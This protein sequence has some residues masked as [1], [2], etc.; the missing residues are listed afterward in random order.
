MNSTRNRKVVPALSIEAQLKRKVR[1]HLNQLGFVRDPDGLLSPPKTEKSTIRL[2]HSFQRSN[3]LRQNQEFINENHRSF[4]AVLADGSELNPE[5]ID[6]CLRPVAGRSKD[7]NLFRMAGLTWSVPVS[8]GFGRRIRYL[9]WDRYHDRLAGVAALGDPVFNLSVRDNEIGWDVKGRAEHLCNLLDA[10]VLGALPPYN[11]LLCGKAIACM[12]RSKEVFDEFESRYGS[13][14]GL[15]SGKIKNP[16]LLAITTSSSM[17]RS[18]V[19]NRLSLKGNTYLR[20][21]G[22]TKGWGHFH[23]PDDLFLELR[24][25]LD[26]IGHPYVRQYEFGEGPNWRL[27]TIKAAFGA[28]GIQQNLLHHGVRR[29]VFVGYFAKNAKAILNGNAS[30]ADISNLLC[31]SEILDAAKERWIIPRSMRRTEYMSWKKESVLQ[32]FDEFLN[33]D[34]FDANKRNAN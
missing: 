16:R 2:L 30:T 17:G 14:P 7:A 20:P 24:K 13:K 27:R 23:V 32:H 18:S 28:L 10:Y 34:L 9:V 5:K 33:N 8:N 21:I 6:L 19:Y 12:L 26:E 25:F 31:E 15:I 22:Y 1:S 11:Q 29:Q 3:K 4:A